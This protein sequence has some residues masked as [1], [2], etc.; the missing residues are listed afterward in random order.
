[1][2][3]EKR[4]LL[5]EVATIPSR[6]QRPRHPI[7]RSRVIRVVALGLLSFILLAQW[8]QLWHTERTAP[9]LSVSK[10]EA[11][12]ATCK[13]L[14]TKPKDPAGHGRETNARYGDWK[15]TLIR[16]AT[17]WTGEPVEGT[18]EAD[19]RAGKGWA[20]RQGDVLL[21]RGLITKVEAKISSDSLPKD[22]IVYEAA[23]RQLTTGIIDMHSHAGVDPLPQLDGYADFNEASDNLTPWARAMDGFF[24]LDPQ[25]EVIKSGGVTTSL[26][27]PGSANNIGGEA[28]LIKH[29][30]GPKDGRPEISAE[31]M[32]ADPERTW[33][34]MK[35][36]CG[37]NPKFLH[38]SLTSRPLTRQ[39][40]SYEF[41][42]AFEEARAMIQR[43]D[44]WCAK[45]DSV[46][47]EN[48]D[49]YLPQTI[50]LESLSAALRG[51]VH[52]NVHCYTIP[53]LEAMVDHTNEFAFQVR[54]FH[55][56]HQ[57]YLVPDILKRTWGGRF[58]SSALFADNMY[59]KTESYIGS[60][61]AGKTLYDAGLTPV[62]VSDNPVL[63]A[64]HVVF[65][66]AK[67]YHYGLPYHAAMASVTTAPADDLGMGHRLGKVK[68]GYD[69][70]VVVWDSD[71]LSVG[72]TP[73]QVWID[74][75]E[76]FEN[77]FELDKPIKEPMVP[78]A[79]LAMSLD[80]AVEV[81]S[82]IFFTGVKKVLVGDK[83]VE[84]SGD[85]GFNVSI[86]KGQVTCVR[87]CAAE[88]EAAVSSG[89]KVIDLT[90]G[91]LHPAYVGFGGTLGLNEIDAETT[92]D[93]GLNPLHF[94]RAI[95]G[96]MLDGKKLQDAFKAGVT[97]A[98]S[99][100]L[101]TGRQ[102]HHGTSVGFSTNAKNILD[103][104]AVFAEDVGVHYT[105]NEAVRGQDSYSA[106]FGKL[107]DVLMATGGIEKDL[108]PYGEE[109]FLK[110]VI[111]LGMPLAL[112]IDS[113]DQI[114]TALR[115]KGDIDALN[116]GWPLRL[117]IVGGAEAHLVADELAA[118]DVGVILSPLQSYG[119]TWGA[120]RALS[121]APLTNGTNIDRLVEAGVTVGIGLRED[122]EVVSLAF[123]AGTAM[124]NSNGRIDERAA[125]DLVGRN[126]LAMMNVDKQDGDH[127]VVSEDSPLEIGSR[128]RAV[129][130]G[131]K[132]TV[133]A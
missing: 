8:Q 107:R 55:H 40:E 61:Q 70:D 59:Y 32:L 26:V 24:P 4:G 31:A 62:Y 115:V 60:K 121:G 52:V 126:I 127:W 98:I 35:M 105:F 46:G 112:T 56:A 48:M 66:A 99:A 84:D 39:G 17:I 113:A 104:D 30:V 22:T 75:K 80:E 95:D 129:A 77:P 50:A 90:N 49:E 16:N 5:P 3:Y 132:V 108:L 47:V 34:Y 133:F 111:E 92:T 2:D 53:D 25:I 124:R 21:E 36:A 97:R 23:G 65:E 10:L 114:A 88:Y 74:G 118:H 13:K 7:R 122:M 63:N 87:D 100:P 9:R 125:F 20:W 102:T 81:E 123:A 69:A 57:T 131:G 51:Q 82:D 1:M 91:Y 71:P 73:V 119:D 41:R 110:R 14:H 45:A 28:L 67:A 86:S 106:A 58:P 27:L 78:D 79:A 64:Q 19:A 68:P 6:P 12:L 38:G 37:E 120:R 116:T 109:A 94:S 18:S 101:F 76:Q 43:Q 117:V 33:R 29:A 96:L 15:P 93:N 130:S 83:D 11:D 128:T 44:D 42:R 89:A 103:P 72:A 54:A 85:A